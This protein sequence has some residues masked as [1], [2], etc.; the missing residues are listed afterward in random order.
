MMGACKELIQTGIICKKTPWYMRDSA[1]M[2]LIVEN[3]KIFWSYVK[4]FWFFPRETNCRIL[5]GLYK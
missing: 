1:C 3:V 5:I 4:H 2:W